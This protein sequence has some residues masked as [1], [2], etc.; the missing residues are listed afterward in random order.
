MSINGSVS[1]SF[2][3]NTTNYKTLTIGTISGYNSTIDVNGVSISSNTTI[4]ISE[5]EIVKISMSFS[6]SASKN[7]TYGNGSASNSGTTTISS[8]TFE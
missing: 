1:N 3:I 5:M 4:D 6:I 8:L 2:E 7:V